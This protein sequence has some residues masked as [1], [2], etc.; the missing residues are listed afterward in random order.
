LTAVDERIFL[1]KARLLEIENQIRISRHVERYALLRQYAAG[2]VVD[3][4]CGCG[5]GSYLLATNPDV[6]HVTGVDM[7]AAA[8]AH[9]AAEFHGP[10]TTFVQDNLESYTSARKI[11]LVVSVETIEHLRDPAV[12]SGFLARNSVAR[13][14]ITY[15]SKKTTHYNRF[16]FHDLNLEKVRALFS[17]YRLQRHF[18]WEH[19]FDVCFF[20]LA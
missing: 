5:Y 18:N 11:D 10:K 14:I 7:D 8:I 13:F 17:G 9:A 20:E 1:S 3:I 4:A 16:H 12:F 15:P 2:H 19:E 6:V